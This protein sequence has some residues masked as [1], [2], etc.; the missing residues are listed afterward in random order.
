MAIGSFLDKIFF[1]ATGCPFTLIA[2]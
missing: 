1:N 2:C